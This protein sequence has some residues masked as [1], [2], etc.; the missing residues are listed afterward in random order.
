MY[1]LAH[2]IRAPPLLRP[3][4]GSRWTP[5]CKQQRCSSYEIIAFKQATLCCLYNALQCLAPGLK[6]S[7]W[8]HQK[9][10]MCCEPQ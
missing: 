10:K 3:A 7:R 1:V 6:M 9:N 8:L 5:R 2:V 4:G